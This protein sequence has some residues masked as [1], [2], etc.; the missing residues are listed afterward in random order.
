[1]NRQ[2]RI[3]TIVNLMLSKE[4]GDIISHNEILQAIHEQRPS[5]TYRDAVHAAV[6]KCVNAGKMVESVRSVGYRVV[7]PD[8]YVS[9]STKCVMSGAKK[10][11]YGTKILLHAPVRDMSPDGVQSYNH[12][13]DRMRMLQAA[14]AGAKVEI[15][16]LGS[17][18]Q[19]PLAITTNT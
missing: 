15:S 18:R 12:V 14:V 4:Y 9:Q 8:E 16:M 17:G 6:K 3:N 1:M 5:N 13:T 11:D 10:I 19:H 7:A 2:D